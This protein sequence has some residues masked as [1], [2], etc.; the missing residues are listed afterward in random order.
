MVK[1]L[2]KKQERL[3]HKQSLSGPIQ[4]K[5]RTHVPVKAMQ[6]LETAF[7]KSF[8]V[9]FQKGT[10][11]I[12]KATHIKDKQEL[13]QYFRSSFDCEQ[14]KQKLKRFD[15]NARK[16]SYQHVAITQ[17]KSSVLG[18]FGIGIPDIPLYLAT[19]LSGIYQIATIYGYD[20]HEEKEQAY[21]LLLICAMCDEE[22]KREEWKNMMDAMEHG[23]KIKYSISELMTYTSH[24]LS[25]SELQSKFLQGI[26]IAGIA[27]AF[28]ST[29][30]QN[31]ILTFA[32]TSY[33]KRLLH[34]GR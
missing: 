26:P 17:V 3:L 5:I 25:Y 32:R 31:R 23:Q 15:Q 4:K 22:E 21:V 10:P 34:Q 30:T 29:S 33:K 12:E 7:E 18:L 2:N 28:M 16:T 19:L 1:K 20:I 14:N 24:A 13:A 6:A 8:V 9:I 11:W 27:G